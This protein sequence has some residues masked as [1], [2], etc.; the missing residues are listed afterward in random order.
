MREDDD[1][2]LPIPEELTLAEL[3]ETLKDEVFIVASQNE[4]YLAT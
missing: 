4:N 2:E 1:F 3:L